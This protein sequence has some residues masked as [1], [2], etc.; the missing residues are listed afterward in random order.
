MRKS[1][2]RK[3]S[4]GNNGIEEDYSEEGFEEE[5]LGNSQLNISKSKTPVNNAWGSK[6]TAS[7]P[8]RGTKADGSSNL[9]DF[10]DANGF[11]ENYPE[12]DFL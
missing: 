5:S 3:S 2:E 11:E 10:S 9:D 12:D 7:D 6:K 4:S 8:K 1:S